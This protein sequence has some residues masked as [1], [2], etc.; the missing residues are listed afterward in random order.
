[1]GVSARRAIRSSDAGAPRAFRGFR[2]GALICWRYSLSGCWRALVFARFPRGRFATSRYSFLG[3]RY[4]SHFLRFPCGYFAAGA[5]SVCVCR[6]SAFSGA[7]ALAPFALRMPARPAFLCATR[8]VARR[9]RYAFARPGRAACAWGR[10]SAPSRPRGLRSD[11][12]K[13]PV[14]PARLVLGAER[15]SRP[16]RTACVW[17]ERAPRPARAV[18]VRTEKSAPAWLR[19]AFRSAY[20]FSASLALSAS[21]VNADGSLMASSESILRLMSTPATFSPFMSLE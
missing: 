3:H 16:A 17:T 20:L 4:V 11:R 10:K 5:A 6:R 1:M 14:P 18:C 2:A 19:G 21:A 7:F 9:F 13:R 12:K 8:G 15:A